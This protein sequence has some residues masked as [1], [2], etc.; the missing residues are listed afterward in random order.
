MECVTPQGQK[1]IVNDGGSGIYEDLLSFSQ[2]HQGRQG[3]LLCPGGLRESTY[4]TCPD[5]GKP[6]S[7]AAEECTKT[8]SN[9]TPCGSTAKERGQGQT[10]YLEPSRQPEPPPAYLVHRPRAGPQSL[11]CPARSL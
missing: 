7:T 2:E 5:C 10:F 4:P 1:F 9:G 11:W 6:R 8:L 3:A